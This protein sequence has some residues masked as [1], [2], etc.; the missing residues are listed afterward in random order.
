[1]ALVTFINDFG[2][3]TC[4]YMRID[5]IGQKA[6]DRGASNTVQKVAETAEINVG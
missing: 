1:M 5:T 2:R 3:D 6:E 4:A